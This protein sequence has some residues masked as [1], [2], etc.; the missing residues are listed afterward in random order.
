[1]PGAAGSTFAFAELENPDIEFVHGVW[2]VEPVE[3]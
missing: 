1:V 2:I 3:G